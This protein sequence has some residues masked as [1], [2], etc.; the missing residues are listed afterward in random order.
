MNYEYIAPMEF[1]GTRPQVN[2]PVIKSNL[3]NETF[4]SEVL[5]DV[6]SITKED[7]DYQR[8]FGRYLLKPQAANFVV[9]R[10]LNE[11]LEA[12]REVFKSK[13]LLPTYGLFSR[14]QGYRSNLHRHRDSNACTYTL[15]VCVSSIT[16]WPLFV[17]NVGYSLKPNEALCFY[18]EDQLHWRDEFPDKENNIVEMTFLHYAEPDHWFFTKPYGFYQEMLKG[19]SMRNM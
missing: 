10:M 18:G 1:M 16:D 15:D 13:T 9:E 14:Y 5:Q 17:E 11:G 4:W 8:N 2:E 12:A 19:G 7:F 6:A 3:F